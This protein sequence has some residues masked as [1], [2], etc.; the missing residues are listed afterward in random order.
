MTGFI[1]VLVAAGLLA[2]AAHTAHEAGWFASL[3]APAFDLTGWSRPG[4]IRASLLTGMLGLQ[5]VPTVA[6]V[7]VWLAYA[8]PMSIYVLWP[9]RSGCGPNRPGRP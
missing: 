6:E 3:Q 4:T 7:T 2:S 8:I 1:L 5:P 9:Q